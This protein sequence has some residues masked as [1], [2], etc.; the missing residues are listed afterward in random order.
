MCKMTLQKRR[1]ITYKKLHFDDGHDVDNK[2]RFE[3]N[4]DEK[5]SGARE[6]TG[7]GAW[8][9][10]SESRAQV[11]WI[12]F[13]AKVFRTVYLIIVLKG[14][15]WNGLTYNHSKN[16]FFRELL[17]APNIFASTPNSF[18]KYQKCPYGHF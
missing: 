18:P 8:G 12:F 3:F 17:R 11:I 13:D 1:V 9:I 10:V 15:F 2:R 4:S 14:T 6:A 7:E 5:A 16:N